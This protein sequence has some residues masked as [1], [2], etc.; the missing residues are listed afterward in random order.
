[1]GSGREIRLWENKWII[2]SSLREGFGNLYSLALDPLVR[3]SDV[4]D[5]ESNIWKPLLHCN[6]NDWEIDDFGRLLE[7]LEGIKSNPLMGIVENVSFKKKDPLLQNFS[8]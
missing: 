2:D 3:V 5:K 1:M 6:L 7:R 4:Y 8:I